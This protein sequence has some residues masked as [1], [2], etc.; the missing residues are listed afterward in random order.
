MVNKNHPFKYKRVIISFIAVLLTFFG[1][2]V[3]AIV[4]HENEMLKQA[5]KDTVD[6]L[7]LMGT[8][9]R[10]SIIRHDYA[11]V[12][13]FLRQWGEEHPEIFE[14]KATAPNNF[15]I[16]HYRRP[17]F[18]A[19]PF[20]FQRQIQYAGTDLI[21]L[22]MIKDLSS[23]RKSLYMFIFQMTIGSVLLTVILGITLWYSLKK[24]ALIPM[25]KE[26]LIREEAEKKF[27]TILESAPDAMV[28]VNRQGKILLINKQAEKLFGYA[29]KE[30]YGK[31]IEILI[32]ERFRGVH[33][34]EREGYFLGPKARPM[35]AGLDLYGL[36]K[37]GVEFPADISLSPIET[38]EGVFVLADIRDITE[39][40]R[41]EEKIMRGYHY[42]K[43]ISSILQISLETIPFEEQMGQILDNIFA[44]PFLPLQAKGSIYLVEDEPDVL[45]LRAQRG[46]SQTILES[47][48]NIHFGK[49]LC[50]LSASRKEIVV[51]SSDA[52]AHE[53]S[54]SGMLPH[55][56]ICVPILSGEKVL[57]I[58]NLLVKED[59]KRKTEDEQLLASVANTIA[60]IIERRRAERDKQK[61]Q[62]QLVEVEKLSALGRMTANVA[63]EIRNPLTA[64]GGYARRL[65]KNIPQGAKEK[66]YAEI[67]ISEVGMLEKILK[68]VLTFSR[69]IKIN[70][71]LH[72]VNEILDES[73]KIYE[74]ISKE[75]S[76]RIDKNYSELP[77]ILVD[78]DHVTEALSNILSNAMDSIPGG[79]I[80]TISTGMETIKEKTY[81]TVKITDTGE[82]IPEDKLD[83]I[84]EPF[85]S[86]KVMGHGTGLGLPI[87]K[88][89]MEDHGGFIKVKS[90][91][92][93]G[94][95]FSLY[96]PYQHDETNT[97][98]DIMQGSENTL[99]SA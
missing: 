75:R 74:I 41:S 35:G 1:I 63:H 59:Y 52:A 65:N 19:H 34:K 4:S 80:L 82:G 88:K 84:F 51:A 55:A 61:L 90:E 77:Q 23:V 11:T 99:K 86:T 79:G 7:E 47:C 25:E 21:N 20:H 38:D 28:F 53:T 31:E 32:P 18:P 6:E 58:M 40:K 43:T 26:I 16:A 70:P 76:I 92:K 66:E 54:Y 17:A 13:Q 10:Q 36:K 5:E 67:I 94:S 2:L 87:S 49:C 60:G 81:V 68:N 14:L 24:L 29:R 8:F 78:K 42:Q 69:E 45:V 15:V 50:G 48:S 9:A 73:L 98:N 96:F 97:D 27:R 57:G 39:K 44:I 62:K 37:D 56:N 89:I 93:K 72:D 91:I 3:I 85:F 71:E 30:L 95:T 83:R 12:E 46:L 64:L 22:Y 33:G